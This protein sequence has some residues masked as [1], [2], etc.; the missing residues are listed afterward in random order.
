MNTTRFW[1]CCGNPSLQPP[2]VAVSES[3]RLHSRLKPFHQ[4][5]KLVI[6]QFTT[7]VTS[8]TQFCCGAEQYVLSLCTKLV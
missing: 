6:K 3:V 7:W 4:V 5:T 8:S 2:S 1:R